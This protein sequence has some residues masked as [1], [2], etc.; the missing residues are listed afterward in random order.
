MS[1]FSGKDP[2]R[3]PPGTMMGEILLD[4]GGKIAGINQAAERM[5]GRPLEEIEGWPIHEAV[6]DQ[7]LCALMQFALIS[8]E[9][10]V[11][12]VRLHDGALRK[13]RVAI[14]PVP[15]RG[16]RHAT[17]LRCVLETVPQS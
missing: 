7:A 9:P 6:G 17:G 11:A 3:T 1:S 16:G 12:P 4:S 15:D 10:I 8:A 13:L 5:I 14:L 2:G